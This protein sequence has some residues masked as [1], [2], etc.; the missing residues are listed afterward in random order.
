MATNGPKPVWMSARKKVNQSSPRAPARDAPSCASDDGAAGA[1]ALATSRSKR[2]LGISSD[3]VDSVSSPAP[4]GTFGV[5]F[6]AA[7]QRAV[8]VGMLIVV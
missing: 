6:L 5:G 4:S 1:S 7:C 3:K 2:P 8:G